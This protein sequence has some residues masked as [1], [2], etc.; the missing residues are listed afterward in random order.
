MSING[1]GQ[2]AKLFLKLD[3]M[4]LRDRLH[5]CYD[6]LVKSEI[7]LDSVLISVPSSTDNVNSV[8]KETDETLN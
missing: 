1:L 3:G 4:R 8:S 5:I 6:I 7:S 2:Q